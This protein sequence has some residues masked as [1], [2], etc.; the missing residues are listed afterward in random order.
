MVVIFN[1][2]NIQFEVNR[3]LFLII[4]LFDSKGFFCSRQSGTRVYNEP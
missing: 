4:R 3:R 1:Q 2:S